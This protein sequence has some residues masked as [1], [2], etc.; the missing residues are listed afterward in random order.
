MF[1]I[2]TVLISYHAGGN[3]GDEEQSRI[4]LKVSLP[5]DTFSAV[6]MKS[7]IQCV[8]L[9]LVA[10]PCSAT[11]IMEAAVLIDLGLAENL[12]NSTAFVADYFT[13]VNEILE[14]IDVEVK[15]MVVHVETEEAPIITRGFNVGVD[16]RITQKFLDPEEAKKRWFFDDGEETSQLEY[17]NSITISS[18]VVIVLTVLEF[19]DETTQTICSKTTKEVRGMARKGGACNPSGNLAV[20]RVTDKTSPFTAAH[21]IGHLLGLDHVDGKGN[22]MSPSAGESKILGWFYDESWTPESLSQLNTMLQSPDKRCLEKAEE[23]LIPFR[24]ASWRR[25]TRNLKIKIP[26]KETIVATSSYWEFVELGMF[27]AGVLQMVY[28][29][30]TFISPLIFQLISTFHRKSVTRLIKEA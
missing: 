10:S 19:C 28:Y 3:G 30:K 12:E 9:L 18:D 29:V 24:T 8:L 5:R 7:I 16:M 13:F 27:G 20:V 23:K 21:E 15:V 17:I 6:K 11:R 14:P 2:F 26:N 1:S 4:S 25:W 22:L